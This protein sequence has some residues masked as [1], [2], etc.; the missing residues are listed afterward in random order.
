MQ[1][2]IV[3]PVR[4]GHLVHVHGVVSR[5]ATAE[6]PENTSC[7]LGKQEENCVLR[8]VKLAERQKARGLVGD[9]LGQTGSK[10]TKDG[11]TILL[12]LCMRFEQLDSVDSRGDR[13]A[14]RELLECPRFISFSILPL[15][16]SLC[17][18]TMHDEMDPLTTCWQLGHPLVGPYLST[19]ALRMYIRLAR[20][21]DGSS[22]GGSGGRSSRVRLEVR[23]HS[24]PSP[25]ELSASYLVHRESVNCSYGCCS[26]WCQNNE[27]SCSRHDPCKH[28]VLSAMVPACSCDRCLRASSTRL[29]LRTA[30]LY[31][32]SSCS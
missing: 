15:H 9:G 14:L 4:V 5:G 27:P 10:R 30:S 12:G 20:I 13:I 8:N 18:A 1:G 24:L 3:V 32:W 6:T 26:L 23:R 31:Q 2:G 19:S 7:E 21:L 28:S 11:V 25:H 22:T 29:S 17:A 16:S